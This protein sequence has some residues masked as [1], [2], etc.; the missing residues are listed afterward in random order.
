MAFSSTDPTQLLVGYDDGSILLWNLAAPS[1]LPTPLPDPHQGFLITVLRFSSDGKQILSAAQDGKI[2]VWNGSQFSRSLEGHEGHVSF[3]EFSPNGRF[4]AS[5]GKD[6]TVRLW[7][8][9]TGV[10]LSHTKGHSTI[11]TGLAWVKGSDFFAT[12][13]FDLYLRVWRVASDGGS[14]KISNI[15]SVVAEHPPFVL[16]SSKKKFFIVCGVELMLLNL[17]PTV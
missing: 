8:T 9:D 2:K 10:C 7:N 4:I 17:L 16:R 3:A 11:I 1:S 13:S 15:A 5:A 14:S 6:L 12:I